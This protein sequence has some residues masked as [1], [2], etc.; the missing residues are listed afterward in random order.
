MAKKKEKPHRALK[1][2]MTPQ[3]V[4]VLDHLIK[5]SD[6]PLRHLHPQQGMQGEIQSIAFAT[7]RE[8][9]SEIIV[10]LDRIPHIQGI[11]FTIVLRKVFDEFPVCIDLVIKGWTPHSM[12]V[13]VI[14]V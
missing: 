13:T 9:S 2:D 8:D 12:L 14:N 11:P 6:V 3:Q 10:R 7:C 1:R 5:W 4:F